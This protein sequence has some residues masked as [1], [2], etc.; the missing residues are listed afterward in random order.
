MKRIRKVLVLAMTLIMAM[1]LNITA[2][3]EGD[4]ITPAGDTATITIQG[5]TQNTTITY[6]QIL[7]NS[8]TGGWQIVDDAAIKGIFDTFKTDDITDPI[9]GYKAATES[10]RAEAF[11]DVTCTD[12]TG[13]NGSTITVTEA[14]LYLIQA[15]DSTG[16]YVYKKMI[17]SVGFEYDENG[18]GKLKNPDPINAKK[19][20]TT[21]EKKADAT[22]KEQIEEITYT[23]D[24]VIPFVPKG[25]TPEDG[26]DYL[27]TIKDVLK[28]GNYKAENGIA[29][30][31]YTLD[32]ATGTIE[33]PVTTI[34]DTSESIVVPL[35]Q[36]IKNSDG[37]I[38]NENADKTITLTYVATGKGSVIENTATPCVWGV[39]R[40]P[41]SFKVVTGK[42]QVTKLGATE[43]VK[44]KDAEFVIINKDGQFALLDGTNTLTGWTSDI[45]KASKI[46]TN[47]DGVAEA[48]GFDR[49]ETYT[50]KEFSAPNGY[51]LKDDVITLTWSTDQ[52]DATG[53]VVEEQLAEGSITDDTLIELPYTGGSGTAVFTAIGVLLMSV[54]AGLYF[55][56]KRK[57][58]K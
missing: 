5:L 50:A 56:S 25:A 27:V 18:N 17:A 38:T 20:K 15:V 48:K 39:D 4:V 52:F 24:M 46:I 43:D 51:T 40:T 45:T 14:G 29:S 41:S 11:K 26:N 44:L 30:V 19:S 37:V 32:G 21:I 34:S 35:D 8:Q 28:N 47:A 53:A 55:A 13:V 10:A 57:V 22:F 58:S 49:E 12:T 7:K 16:E 42:I 9:K 33:V 2:F 31:G 6:K 3:A 1:A 54:A 23:V 36:F